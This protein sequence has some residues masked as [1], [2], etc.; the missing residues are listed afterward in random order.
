MATESF[1]KRKERLESYIN[2]L[3][4]VFDTLKDKTLTEV[5]KRL[6]DI[7]RSYLEDA[8]YYMEKEDIDTGLICV[9]YAEGLLDA[10]RFLGR[11]SFEW[12]K[13]KPMRVALAGTFDII[14]PGHVWLISE[15]AKLGDLTIIISRDVTVERIKG[16]PPIN[17]ENQ[18]AYVVSRIKGVRKVV[19]G[20]REDIL[21]PILRIKPDILVLGP[22]QNVDEE[23]LKKKLAERGLRDVRIVRIRSKF[24]DFEN[25]ST[26]KIIERVLSLYCK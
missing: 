5:D 16:H 18:R 21:I 13:R 11:I 24:E 20:D 17:S 25:C 26:S 15:A 14:H 2:A 8:I 12:R 1:E 10:L 9:S 4:K 7:A 23:E 19:L 3:S 6:V 22:D